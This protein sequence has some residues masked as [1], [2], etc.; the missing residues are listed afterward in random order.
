MGRL[1][2]VSFAAFLPLVSPSALISAEVLSVDP[3]SRVR[4]HLGRAGMMGFM[5]HAHEIEAPLV[6]GRVEIPDGDPARSSVRL[7]FD[8]RR[9]AVVPGSE[10]AKD[11]PQVEAR[12]R[13][14]EVLDVERFPEITFESTAVVAEGTRL[15]VRGTLGLKG[16]RFPVEVP[17]TA[18][19]EGDGLVATGETSLELRALGIEPP[20][21]GGVVKVANSFRLSFEIH[22]R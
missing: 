3:A 11:V 19:R 7:R 20:S 6:E 1:C 12:M 13:G 8:S 15:R 9:L 5:G 18:T 10:P 17:L 2:V 21:V 14:P 16:G 22:A 4:I